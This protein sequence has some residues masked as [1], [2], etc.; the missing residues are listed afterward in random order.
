MSEVVALVPARGGSRGL[1][2][3]NLRE[4]DGLP[5]IAWT[6]RQAR[7]ARTID[8]VV[9]STDDPEIARVASEHGAEAPW[10]RPEE[11][12]QDD[13]RWIDAVMHGL[14]AVEAEGPV[15]VLCVLQPTSPLRR[16]SD[17]DGAVD[18]VLTG[19][20]DAV[21]SVT[22]TG[23]PLDLAN[24]LPRDGCMDGFLGPGL[25]DTRRQELPEY[26]RLNGSIYAARP[27]YLRARSGFHGP[28]TFA[29]TMPRGRSV[30]IDDADDFRFA[31]ALIA[32]QPRH[33]EAIR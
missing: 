26:Y 31:E 27:S 16:P 22:K 8:R 15:E 20:A 9:V 1:P 25:K 28:R 7:A 21:V 5:L 29:W 23:F 19:E 33:A 24:T 32:L 17:I 12:A 3:K 6:V 30:D 11:L 13:S 18:R 10:L 4:L 14:A 2:R